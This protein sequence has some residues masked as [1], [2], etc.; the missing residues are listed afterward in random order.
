MH[1]KIKTSIITPNYNRANYI[2]ET[3]QSVTNQTYDNWECIVVDD[4]STDDSLEIIKSFCEKDKRIK[5]FHRDR[6]PKGA[7]TCRNIG[8]ENS[9]AEYVIFLDSDD[10]IATY[11]LQRR[12]KIIEENP[13]LD[14]AVFPM[15]IFDEKPSDANKLWNIDNGNNHLKRLLKLDPIAQGSGQIWKKESLIKIGGWNENLSVWQDIDLSIRAFAN[16]FNYITCFDYQPDLFLRLSAANSISRKNLFTEE[17]ILGRKEVLISGFF[18]LKNENIHPEDFR[19]MAWN[20]LSGAVRGN[21]FNI[22]KEIFNWAV[23]NNILSSNHR[24]QFNT[25]VYIQKLKL[26]SFSY[27]KEKYQKL[28]GLI[29]TKSNIGKHSYTPIK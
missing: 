6:D 5:L 2:S 26:Y 22:A 15:L 29:S 13:G 24:K 14:Y 27:F 16:K 9:N 23:K 11:C 3:L 7:G 8:L 19:F 20:V 21:K 17:K 4:G 1:S 25:L 12:I 18:H 28:L 10:I